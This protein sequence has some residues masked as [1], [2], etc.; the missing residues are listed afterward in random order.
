MKKTQRALMFFLVFN[1]FLGLL[2]ATNF[3]GNDTMSQMAGYMSEGALTV[4]GGAEMVGLVIMFFVVAFCYFTHL[5]L[6]ASSF[7]VFFALMVL[8]MGGMLPLV[9]WYTALFITGAIIAWF[10]IKMIPQ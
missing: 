2:Q 8:G 3:S 7:I 1:A 9:I 6:D 5:P 10:V 4:L